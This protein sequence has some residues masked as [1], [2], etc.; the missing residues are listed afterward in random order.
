MLHHFFHLYKLFDT[1]VYSVVLTY[2]ITCLITLRHGLISVI[3]VSVSPEMNS[4]VRHIAMVRGFFCPFL[5]LNVAQQFGDCNALWI[6]K[7]VL[8]W[9]CHLSKSSLTDT[10]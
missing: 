6:V 7:L 2:S 5:S 1:D 8:Y 9:L 10:D 4:A 3:T